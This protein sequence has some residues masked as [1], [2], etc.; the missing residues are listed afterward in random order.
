[1]SKSAKLADYKD[2]D[3]PSSIQTYAQFLA[4][5]C[6]EHKLG[7]LFLFLDKRGDG[8]IHQVTNFNAGQLPAALRTLAD[9]IEDE[10]PKSKGKVTLTDGEPS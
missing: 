7:F 3:S 4:S 5:K 2:T 10:K 6:E 8:A 9:T 1:M